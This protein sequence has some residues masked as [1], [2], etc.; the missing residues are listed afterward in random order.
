MK[1]FAEVLNQSRLAISKF[2]HVVDAVV[3]TGKIFAQ[4][5]NSDKHY[6]RIISPKRLIFII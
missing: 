3:V 1:L 6:I 4:S 5:D 2:L